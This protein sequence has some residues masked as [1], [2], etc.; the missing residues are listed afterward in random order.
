MTPLDK[1]CLNI[2]LLFQKLNAERRPGKPRT[3]WL[4]QAFK[5]AFEKLGRA[6]EYDYDNPEHQNF[7]IQNAR[8]R[9]G[10]FA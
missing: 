10:V 8:E 2:T 9:L 4:L 5:D 7:V 1:F 6:E 3:S